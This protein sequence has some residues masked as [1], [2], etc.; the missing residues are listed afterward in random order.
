MRVVPK[1][2]TDVGV[3]LLRILRRRHRPRRLRRGLDGRGDDA[4]HVVRPAQRLS[5]SHCCCRRR[6]ATDVGVLQ[7][8][9]ASLAPRRNRSF[10][11]AARIARRSLPTAGCRRGHA[12]DLRD[13]RRRRRVPARQGRAETVR[14]PRPES[15]TPIMGRSVCDARR[16]DV[17]RAREKPS[18]RRLGG[19]APA[20]AVLCVHAL[21]RSRGRHGDGVIAA[22]DEV[23]F[24]RH[25]ARESR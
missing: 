7:P 18:L 15:K 21:S 13:R 19:R 4:E 23:H 6:S 12:R 17:N 24:A 10:D 14:P 16:A 2:A 8:S 9:S 5:G 25:R 11:A 3:V 22:I 1:T 20:G